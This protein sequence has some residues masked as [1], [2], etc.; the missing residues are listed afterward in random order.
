MYR[1]PRSRG[2]GR[3]RTKVTGCAALSVNTLV[4]Q[5]AHARSLTLE[6]TAPRRAYFHQRSGASSG[7]GEPPLPAC[8]C[9]SD[10]S[11]V[12]ASVKP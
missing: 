11:F 9:P 2:C 12:V 8:S 3:S 5:S 10:F 6:R 1:V 4:L 7:A